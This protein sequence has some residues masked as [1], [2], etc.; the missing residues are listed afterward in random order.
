[1]SD[2]D[3]PIDYYPEQP[4]DAAQESTPSSAP[5][6]S[7]IVVSADSGEMLRECVARVLA[8]TMPLELILVDNG[9]RDGIPQRIARARE[10][11]PRFHALFQHNNLGFGPAVDFTPYLDELSHQLQHQYL[12]TFT[13]KPE[14]KAG[15]QRVRLN[16]ETS[17]VELIYQKSVFVPATPD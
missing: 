12:L 13:P 16:T 15:L 6:L 8:C 17:G 3:L 10:N 11:D 7:V 2:L 1:M 4:E 9:S 5:L 14:K